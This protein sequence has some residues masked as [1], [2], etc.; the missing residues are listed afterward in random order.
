[1]TGS[2]KGC[3]VA[4]AECVTG[5]PAFPIQKLVDTTGAHDL[6]AAVPADMLVAR[7]DV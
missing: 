5:V 3:V 6:F 4:S 1:V 2:E 7:I